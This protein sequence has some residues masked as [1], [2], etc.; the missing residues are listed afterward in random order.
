MFHY[1][2][3]R[4]F[5]VFGYVQPAAAVNAV[6]GHVFDSLLDSLADWSYI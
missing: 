2:V 4:A 5:D 3:D 6:C 1:L